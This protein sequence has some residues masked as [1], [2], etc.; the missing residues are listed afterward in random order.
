MK[1]FTQQN[2]IRD[3]IDKGSEV[4]KTIEEFS[5]IE[6]KFRAMMKKNSKRERESSASK[7]RSIRRK[8]C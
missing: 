2:K 7:F 5:Q 3:F 4:N 8:F 1:S 6:L